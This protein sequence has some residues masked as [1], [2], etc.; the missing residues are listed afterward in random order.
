MDILLSH[1]VDHMTLWEHRADLIL[2]KFYARSCIELGQGMCTWKEFTNRWRDLFRNKWQ[3]IQEVMDLHDQRGIRSCFF[4]G[5]ANG[6]GLAYPLDHSEHWIP[7]VQARGF[8][9]GVHGIAYDNAEG[10]RTEFDRYTRIGGPKAAGIRMHYLRQDPDTITRLAA[11]GYAFNATTHGMR[12]PYRVGAM[13]EFPLQEMD[14]WA[15]CGDRRYRSR[16]LVEAVAHTTALLDE[17]ERKGLR[18][19]SLLFH[20]RYFSAS[21]EGWRAWYLRVLDIMQQRG[22]RFITHAQAM[23]Q[24][25]TAG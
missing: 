19:F 11:T 7:I 6:K 9:T 1:D 24:L 4:F 8:E 3:N 12:D 10:I 15:L 5:M 25:N 20:D 2:P 23:H 14:G 13:W 22:H 21:F 16:T 18:Y 17:A